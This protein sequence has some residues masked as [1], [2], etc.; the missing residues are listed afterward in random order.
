M[1]KFLYGE[2]TSR[3]LNSVFTVHSAVGP[4]LL[5]SV[6][7]SALC[8]EFKHR[9]IKVERQKEFVFIYRGEFAGKYYADIVVEDKIILELKSVKTL[10][11]I[12]RAQTI[13]YLRLSKLNVGFQIN[14]YDTKTEF[15]RCFYDL[16]CNILR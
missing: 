11:P 13:N 15:K 12:M 8:I 10:L 3:V 14:F 7:E 2:L 6:Y 16:D 1:S 4:G 5:E 9:G